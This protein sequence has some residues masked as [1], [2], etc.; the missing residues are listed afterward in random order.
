MDARAGWQRAAAV[1]PSVLRVAAASRR[2]VGE[3]FFFRCCAH[4]AHGPPSQKSRIAQGK[5]GQSSR[6]GGMTVPRYCTHRH[7]RRRVEPRLEQ[8]MLEAAKANSTDTTANR[9]NRM[10][11]SN[12]TDRTNRMAQDE[13]SLSSVCCPSCASCL[14]EPI[15]HG[16]ISARH[17][18]GPA[19]DFQVRPLVFSQYGSNDSS[20]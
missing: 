18:P 1:G 12:R 2:E 9:I 20:E 7:P 3:R 10:D 8:Q 15:A 17:P 11:G 19:R 4:G 5:S 6:P 13:S 16:N 14:I